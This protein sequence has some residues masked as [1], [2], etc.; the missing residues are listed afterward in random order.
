MAG[1]S[2]ERQEYS[3][4]VDGVLAKVS[5]YKEKEA[6]APTYEL[7][8]PEVEPA[9][10]AVL[11]FVRQRI[12]ETTPI[13]LGE[14]VDPKSLDIV[15]QKFGSRA[16]DLIGSEF[17]DLSGEQK[18]WLAGTLVHEMLGLGK[19]ELLLADPELEEIVINSSR[20][21]AW[22]YHKKLGWLKSNIMVP[23][24]EQIYN[25]ATIIGRRVGRQITTLTPLMDAHMLTGD[26][27][28]ATLFPISSSGNTITIRKFA[29]DPWTIVHLISPEY[30]TLSKEVAAL[31]WLC[32]EYELNVLIA[33]GTASGKTSML[34]A[35]MPFIPPT[36]RIISIE[37]T[38]EL[39]LPQ[40]LHW[41]PLT[42]REPNPEGKGEVSMLDLMVNSLRM[43]PD[44]VVLG[45]IRR[46]R[47]AEVLFE[48][49]HTGHSVYSTLHADRVEQVKRRLMSP[50]I[51][52]PEEMLEALHLV[53]VQYRQRRL[54]IRR[55]FEVAEVIP[56]VQ[57]DGRV[58]IGTGLLYRWK[59]R[60][61]TLEKSWKSVRLFDEI[62]LHTGMSDVEIDEEL[63]RKQQIL[64]WMLGRKVRTVNTVGKV[65]ADY[66][67]DKSFVFDVAEKNKPPSAILSEDLL[68]E[69][70]RPIA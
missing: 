42:T 51:S 36:N 40:Y 46:Q 20:E 9:T 41:I 21:P 55:T 30:N 29:R 54:R 56:S 28:N 48:A 69:L 3:L 57:S 27:V 63:R 4:D 38:R 61:D 33:G 66:Y 62:S 60:T 58:T 70:S 43:R 45:E 23:S 47:E 37:D 16:I 22:V 65:I 19:L 10:L 11:D 17:P 32:I 52:L 50:P 26:R 35:I 31:L 12:V 24:E 13:T 53:V 49:M 6:Y 2:D 67:N 1:R 14:I 64:D 68:K 7:T 59:P 44:R 8:A 25:Y 5:I 39:A 15:K 18:G 34:N